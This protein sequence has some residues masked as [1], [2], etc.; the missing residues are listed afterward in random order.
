MNTHNFTQQVKQPTTDRGTM[1]DHVYI[2]TEIQL[3]AQV[4]VSD[5]YYS[6]IILIMIVSFYLF[7]CNLL[8][9]K[10]FH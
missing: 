5:T 10:L 4:Q 3:K 8:I 6:H 7:H 1:I 9:A 2:K